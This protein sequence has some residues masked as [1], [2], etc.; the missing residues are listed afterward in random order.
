R[1]DVE[2]EVNHVA[3]LHDV[4]LPLEPQLAGLACARLAATLDERVV[5][6]N[7][8]T[9]EAPL[10]VGM[11]RSGRFRRGRV[12]PNGPCSHFFRPGRIEGLQTEQTVRCTDN[13]VQAGLLKP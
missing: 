6:D 7:F 3:F 10:K 9:D 2:P 12:L 8:R 5:C 13:P 11:D 1:S 4:S